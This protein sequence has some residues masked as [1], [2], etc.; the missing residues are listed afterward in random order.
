MFAPVHQWMIFHVLGGGA[1]AEAPHVDMFPGDATISRQGVGDATLSRQ[2]VG[3]ATISR[4]GV[5]NAS[6]GRKGSP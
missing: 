6:V 5:G 2:G 1:V 3:N 4:Q